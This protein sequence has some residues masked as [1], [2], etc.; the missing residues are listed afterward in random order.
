MVKFTGNEF[1]FV[2]K[3]AHQFE[4]YSSYMRITLPV[5][6]L[7]YRKECLMAEQGPPKAS[8]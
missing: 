3:R 7:R 1:Y 5:T 8:K 4:S 6:E 2:S